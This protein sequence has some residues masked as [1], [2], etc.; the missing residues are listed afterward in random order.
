[1][2]KMSKLR[3][4]SITKGK[5]SNSKHNVKENDA[6]NKEGKR[7]CMYYTDKFTLPFDKVLNIDQHLC[8]EKYKPESNMTQN[9]HLGQRKLLLSEIQLLTRYYTKYPK[10][11]PVMLYIGSATGSHL[12]ALHNMFPKVRFILYDYAK[13]DIKLKALPKVFEIHEGEDGFFTTDK[14]KALKPR[15]SKES[16]ILVSDIRQDGGSKWS[17]FENGI[18]KDMEL[19][20]EWVQTL[21]PVMSLLKFRMVYNQ[22]ENYKLPYIKGVIYYGIW[23]PPLSGET[24]LLIEKEDN[25]KIIDYVFNTYE[26]G[27]FFHNK[28]TRQYCFN[29]EYLEYTT[30][31]DNPYCPCYDCIA[32]LNVL[33]E[34]AQLTKKKL[35]DIIKLFGKLAHFN[36]LW[37][38]YKDISK[39]KKSVNIDSIISKS[40]GAVNS[41]HLI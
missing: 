22:G 25:Y 1:M 20:K 38:T 6:M 9:I 41:R 3:N 4:N 15:L 28:Y 27:M 26:E 7:H 2:I 29:N 40:C 39:N 12:I 37:N 23:A 32:E 14:C 16:L 35:K 18:K 11:D 31:P 24:R 5:H 36:K 13:F 21:N 33:D 34:Y 17:D 30:M 10:V 8:K 19:Q